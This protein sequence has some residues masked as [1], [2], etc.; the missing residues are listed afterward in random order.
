MALFLIHAVRW[1][2]DRTPAEL[3]WTSCHIEASGLRQSP[4]TEVDVLDAV[5]ALDRG[6]SVQVFA[7]GKIGSIV[8][9]LQRAD[10]TESIQDIEG[11]SPAN[12]LTS[13]PT[14]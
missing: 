9:A 8:C 11:A 13:L 10:G 12:R 6:D 1:A 2:A 7:G 5:D 3:R 4:V 14:F